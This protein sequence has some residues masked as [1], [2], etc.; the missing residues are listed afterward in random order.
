MSNKAIYS[1]VKVTN[2]KLFFAVGDKS[3]LNQL[4]NTN[5]SVGRSKE[6]AKNNPRTLDVPLLGSWKR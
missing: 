1:K 2:R 5:D 6:Q 3:N 4:L